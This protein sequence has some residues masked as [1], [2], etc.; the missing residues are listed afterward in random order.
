MFFESWCCSKQILRLL[1]WFTVPKSL[2]KGKLC[3][4]L[5]IT[6]C[7]KCWHTEEFWWVS[8]RC[9]ICTG[10]N[11]EGRNWLL[12]LSKQSNLVK[13]YLPAT[14]E[15]RYFL[16]HPGRTQRNQVRHTQFNFKEGQP[17]GKLTL[18]SLATVGVAGQVTAHCSCQLPGHLESHML[19]NLLPGWF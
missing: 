10:Q 15:D 11:R 18:W 7:D 8:E 5:T 12:C 2:L 1:P 16:K 14:P 4:S 9:Y 19:S 17:R 6:E 3:D 13:T